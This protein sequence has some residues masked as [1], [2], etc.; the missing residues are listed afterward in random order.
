MTMARQRMAVNDRHMQV[1]TTLMRVMACV[2]L[3]G[4]MKMVFGNAL[5]FGVLAPT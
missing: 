4:H 5:E 1:K 3:I 2:S